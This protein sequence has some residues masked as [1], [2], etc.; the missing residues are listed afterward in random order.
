M[1]HTNT[2]P[3]SD[4]LR[5][6]I[7]ENKL[8]NGID[9]VR[10]KEIWSDITGVYISKATTQIYVSNQSLFVSVNSS[11]LRN[12]IMLIKSQLVQKINEQLGRQ[13]IKEIILR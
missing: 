3:I 2:T 13:Y 7:K 9:N 4:L 11:I 12:E 6:F 1:K 5:Q 8:E 10:I